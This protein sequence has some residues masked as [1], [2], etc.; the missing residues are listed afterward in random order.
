MTEKMQAVLITAPNKAEVREITKPKPAR[1]E[2]L[3]RINATA[4]CTWEQR[5]FV[6]EKKVPLP[7]VGG[8]ET[9]GQIAALGEGVDLVKYPIGQ[10]VA[11][12]VIKQC[13]SC[14][15]CRA[16]IPNLCEETSSLRLDGPEVYGMGGLAEYISLDRSSVWLFDHDVPVKDQ[17]MTEPLACVLNSV[18]RA[19][20]QPGDDVLIVGGGVMGLL[21]V[22]V[23]KLLGAF[24]I[25]SEPNPKRRKI[26]DSIGCHVTLDPTHEDL[27][28]AIQQ[29]TGGRGPRAVFNTTAIPAIAEQTLGLTGKGGTFVMYSSQ[30]P[31]SPIQVSP[32]W[33]H[34][35]EVRITGAVNP[36]TSSFDQAVRTIDKGIL[37]PGGLVTAEFDFKDCQ[38]AFEAAVN[39][40]NFRVMIKFR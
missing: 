35:T 29:L 9:V 19:S 6:G 38:A 25:L 7:L 4:L 13:N 34:N 37:Q 14:I 18:S 28:Q 12:R 30:H 11:V 21:H 36:S 39:P 22:A 40:E 10:A 27:P 20:I 24:T 15:Y 31:D 26:A 16:G 33:V 8:H 17:V 2:V 32:N 23:A 3:V 5:V 1:N